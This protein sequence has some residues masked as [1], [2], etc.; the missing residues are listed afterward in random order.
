MCVRVHVCACVFVGVLVPQMGLRVPTPLPVGYSTASCGLLI[1]PQE[2][3]MM[4][5]SN[6]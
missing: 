1:L 5:G 4:I 3:Q 2:N 6:S